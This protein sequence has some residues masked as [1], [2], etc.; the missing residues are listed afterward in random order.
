MDLSY[1]FIT[2]VT[3]H[4]IWTKLKEQDLGIQDKLIGKGNLRGIY[5]YYSTPSKVKSYPKT[6]SGSFKNI[7]LKLL[8]YSKKGDYSKI[9]SG[10]PILILLVFCSVCILTIRL[11]QK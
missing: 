5:L 3:C 6:T 1:P 11:L 4:I 9:S 7:P 10:Q 8:K 2:M